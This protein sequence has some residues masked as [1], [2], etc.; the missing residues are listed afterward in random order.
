[1]REDDV[2]R[3][4]MSD[5]LMEREADV[6][7]SEREMREET[8]MDDELPD[9]F[10]SVRLS[11]PSVR[12]VKSEEDENAVSME[13]LNA[14]RERDTPSTLKKDALPDVIFNVTSEVV[15]IGVSEAEGAFVVRG[16]SVRE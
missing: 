7:V 1:M 6:S 8:E 5:V 16:E 3:E 15:V 2:W 13:M 12:S 11:V 10:I 4:E 14:L 9:I